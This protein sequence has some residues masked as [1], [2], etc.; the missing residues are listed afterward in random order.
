M[1]LRRCF[2]IPLLKHEM[3][4]Y[5]CKD[6]NVPWA[7]GFGTNSKG[8][9]YLMQMQAKKPET[10]RAER[11][12][13]YREQTDTVS[14]KLTNNINKYKMLTTLSILMHLQDASFDARCSFTGQPST[15]CSGRGNKRKK[16]LMCCQL[17]SSFFCWFFFYFLCGKTNINLSRVFLD[18]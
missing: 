6:S 9:D 3:S 15:S 4:V 13:Q 5:F 7:A 14:H 8:N 1:S 2:H 10:S 16:E 11:I 18:T 12:S 17:L